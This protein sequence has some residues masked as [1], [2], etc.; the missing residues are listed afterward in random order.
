MRK[1]MFNHEIT[2]L[3]DT[4]RRLL[5]RTAKINLIKLT[6]KT[7]PADLAEVFRHFSKEE[8][9]E[10]FSLMKENEHAAEFLVELDDALVIELL[11]NESFDRIASIIK[12][13]PTNDQS[14]ILNILGDKKAQ[15]IIELLNAE[16]QEEIAEIMGYPDDSA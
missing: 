9:I 13:A 7:H 11:E 1:E 12:K 14:C 10:I 15:S 2:I 8:Q 16:E 6:G 3:R 4:Y 5:R